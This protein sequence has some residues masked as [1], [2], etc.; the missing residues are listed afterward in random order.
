MYTYVYVYIYIYIHT[1]TYIMN[2]PVRSIF[3][4]RISK[5]GVWVERI[6]T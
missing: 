3:K 6:L 2:L 1:H 5:F 4:L